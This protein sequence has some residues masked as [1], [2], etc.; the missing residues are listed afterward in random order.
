MGLA[1]GTMPP[2]GRLQLKKKG[3]LERHVG[4]SD[5]RYVEIYGCLIIWRRNSI[6]SEIHFVHVAFVNEHCESVRPLLTT[7]MLQTSNL[8]PSPGK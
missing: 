6:R 4:R 2:F 5:I 1:A 8:S 3:H 7:D